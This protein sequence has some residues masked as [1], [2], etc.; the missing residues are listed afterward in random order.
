MKRRNALSPEYNKDNKFIMTA[1]QKAKSAGL[2]N[3]QQVSE[4]TKQ[5]SGTL[6]NWSNKNTELFKVIL[7]ECVSLANLNWILSL[8]TKDGQ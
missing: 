3:L 6:I 1:S 7:L 4:L 2:K 8:N 5:S